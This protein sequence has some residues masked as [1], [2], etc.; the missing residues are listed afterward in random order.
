MKLKKKKFKKR[1]KNFQDTV[2]TTKINIEQ[3]SYIDDFG[4]D[5]SAFLAEKGFFL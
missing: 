3:S 5:F 4:V 1:T 2:L